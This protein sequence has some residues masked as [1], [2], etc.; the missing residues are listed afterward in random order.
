VGEEFQEIGLEQA[1]GFRVTPGVDGDMTHAR[2][3]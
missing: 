2:Y 1:D 3:L